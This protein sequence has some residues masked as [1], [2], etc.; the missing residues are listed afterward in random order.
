VVREC[1]SQGRAI[2]PPLRLSADWL[3]SG[4]GEIIPSGSLLTDPEGRIVAVGP[5]HHVPTAPGTRVEHYPSAILIPGLV[6][7]HTHL[8]LTGFE[9]LADEPEF[10]DW[11]RTIIRLKAGRTAADFLQAS[12]RGLR[13]GYAA[14]V[15]TVA[16]TGD[17]GAPFEALLQ[18]NGSGIAYLEVFGP[19]PALAEQQF[20]AFRARVLALKPRQTRRVRLG[21]SPHAPYS[22]S[23]PL[24]RMVARLAEEEQLPMAVHIAESAA[25]VELLRDAGG[26]FA[27]QWSLRGIPLPPLPGRTP[28][29]W[30]EQHGVLG[31]RTLCIHAVRADPEDIARMVRHQSGV[32][33]CPRSNRRHGHGAAPLADF[34]AHRLR[35]GLGSDS[36]AS[37]YPADLLAEARAARDL[38]GLTAD[39]CLD[40]VMLGAARALDLDPELGS[41]SAGKWADCAVVRASPSLRAENVAESILAGGPGDVMATWLAGRE[42]FRQS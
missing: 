21:V 11:I 8:E 19:D 1:G 32:A 13:D 4:E 31:P 33:H 15:T 37:V 26:P 10:T 14:A 6:N 22:V 9:G 16:D 3:Y 35:V 29:A 2:N 27:A 39:Q 28:M 25:E 24:Y 40:L 7:A 36:A 18:E 41:L 20:N 23:G 12:A 34:R 42:V 5:D 30:L 17:S 38:A